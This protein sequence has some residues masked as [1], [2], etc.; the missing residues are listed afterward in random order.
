MALGESAESLVW[1]R[2]G[3]PV[4]GPVGLKGRGALGGFVVAGLGLGVGLAAAAAAFICCMF[5]MICS[6]LVTAVG[7][8]PVCQ[9]KI[10]LKVPAINM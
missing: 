4:E 9:D 6:K 10:A 1:G 3:A 8:G 2:A 5:W 7:A